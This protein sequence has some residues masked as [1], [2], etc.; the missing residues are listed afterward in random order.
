MLSGIHKPQVS[1][2]RLT[3]VNVLIDTALVTSL[4]QHGRLARTEHKGQ[5][6]LSSPS[7]WRE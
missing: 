2:E 5:F 7:A 3:D 1:P 6:S 4:A